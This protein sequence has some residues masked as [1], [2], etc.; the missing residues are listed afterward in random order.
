MHDRA[1]W[2]LGQVARQLTNGIE[3]NRTQFNTRMLP[4][5]VYAFGKL[6]QTLGYH[7]DG[8]VATVTDGANKTTHLS[9]W[10]HGIPGLIR[11]P[12]N[13]TESAEIVNP[14][15]IR[16][17]EDEAQSR[18]CYGYDAMGRVNLVT[19]TSE[20]S[21]NVCDT[22]TWNA[23]TVRFEP[24]GHDEYGIPAGHWRRTESTGNARKLTY[25]DALWRPV[26]EEALDAADPHNTT[27]WVAKRYDAQG[28][29]AFQSYP[30]NPLQ[31]GAVTWSGVND[32]THTA[33]DALDRPL[34]VEQDSEHGRLVTITRYL[35]GFMRETTNPKQQVTTERFQVF[36]V[37]TFDFPTQI[38]APESTRTT[39]A[40]DVFG[41]PQAMTRSGR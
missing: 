21:P 7:T 40:R 29:V 39:I 34:R 41:K 38:D 2:V 20:A 10:K 8:T 36:D 31:T 19:R 13:T 32:G 30:R 14:G 12:D 35:T 27:S 5:H 24:V 37:P 22:S 33:Y 11:H 16:W 6:E 3:T 28:R 15:L 26:V 23:T 4:E 1:Q 9:N 18:T 17:V 25:F